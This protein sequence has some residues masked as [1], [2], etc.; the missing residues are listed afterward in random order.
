M[1]GVGVIIGL[2][3]SVCAISLPLDDSTARPKTQIKGRYNCHCENGIGS[4]T[5]QQSG[6]RMTCQKTSSDT[7]NGSCKMVT[8]TRGLGVTPLGGAAKTR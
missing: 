2:L 1:R 3:L 5:S 8:F 4:C 7:C 6:D